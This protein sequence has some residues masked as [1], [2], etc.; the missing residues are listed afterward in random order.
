ME[1][2]N[3]GR[4]CIYDALADKRRKEHVLSNKQQLDNAESN[5]RYYHGFLENLLTSIRL[6]STHQVDQLV[7]VIQDTVKNPDP[8][9]KSGYSKIRET[10][11]S[12]L[13][14]VEDAEGSDETSNVDQSESGR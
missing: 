9:N 1:C 13:S 6:G 11:L 8:D 7:Q 5:L 4:D 2:S 10:I 3:H 14:E 12:I